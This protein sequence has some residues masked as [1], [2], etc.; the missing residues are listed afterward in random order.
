[1]QEPCLTLSVD[2][3][4]S[5]TYTYDQ[6]HDQTGHPFHL[7][8]YKSFGNSALRFRH[9]KYKLVMDLEQHSRLE[10]IAFER[11]VN[12]NHR[13]FDEIGSRP[14]QRRIRRRALAERPDAEIAVPQFGDVSP[15]PEQRLDESPLARFLDGLIEPGSNAGEPLEVV[16][17]EGLC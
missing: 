5:G 9:L 7:A 2:P 6:R 16:F 4:L 3:I 13:D 15:P 10:P 11:G 12:T 14:L 8:F 17:N 1:M